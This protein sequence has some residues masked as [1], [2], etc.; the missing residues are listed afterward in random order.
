[1]PNQELS[2]EHDVARHCTQKDFSDDNS[3]WLTGLVFEPTEKNP[4]IS[5]NWVD[6]YD[7]SFEKKLEKL[8][9][10]L[11]QI[12]VVRRTH[13]LAI[14]NVGKAKEIGERRESDL[15]I[16]HSPI[17]GSP[18]HAE[19]SGIPLRAKILQQELADVASQRLV[20]AFIDD[21][22]Q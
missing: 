19:I 5:V 16:A 14:L 2:L 20:S 18:S 6:F 7:G 10:E 11:K 15:R 21:D 13:Q 9:Q 12:R 4:V 22:D 17:P 1:M 3:E 8:R